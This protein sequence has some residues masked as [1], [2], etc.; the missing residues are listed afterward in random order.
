MT[1]IIGYQ[2]E[3]EKKKEQSVDMNYVE[4]RG[5]HIYYDRYMSPY[6]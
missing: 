6:Y 2:K 1:R 5:R 3:K 4:K